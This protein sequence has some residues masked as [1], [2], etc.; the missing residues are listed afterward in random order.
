ML[1]QW[2]FYFAIERN[3]DTPIHTQI[4]NK[5][6][7]HIKTGQFSSG[8]ALPGSRELAANLNV[9]RKTVIHA[10]DELIAEGWLESANRKGTF[11]ANRLP[12]HISIDSISRTQ[13][14]TNLS[15]KTN[16]A[17]DRMDKDLNPQAS[18]YFPVP[19]SKLGKAYRQ[20][21]ILAQKKIEQQ[22]LYSTE[23]HLLIAKNLHIQKS[24]SVNFEHILTVTNREKAI[25]LCAMQLKNAQEYIAVNEDCQPHLIEL[26]KK[27]GCS[28]LIIKQHEYGIDLMDLEKLCINYNLKLFYISTSSHLYEH[29]DL[30]KKNRLELL[31]LS[32]RFSFTIIEDDWEC[33]LNIASKRKPLLK[34]ADSLNNVIYISTLCD[35]IFPDL[36]IAYIVSNTT[37]D[38]SLKHFYHQE[39]KQSNLVNELAMLALV[40]NGEIRKLLTRLR[41]QHLK[42]NA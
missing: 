29:T 40:E 14:A 36:N 37:H 17:V 16:N 6:I 18:R 21:S 26:L 7:A 22:T 19:S 2:D 23:L 32:Y 5:I 3:I 38:K 34:S 10:Y 20:A 15:S 30:H 4:I 27:S 31:Q 42:Q 28:I 39:L 24:L 11:I 33:D 8:M 13:N 12:T 25:W 41:H 35:W 9:N 1:R